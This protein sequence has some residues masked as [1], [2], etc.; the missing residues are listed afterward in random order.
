MQLKY[1]LLLEFLAIVI[2]EHFSNVK[3][4]RLNAEEISHQGSG[5]HKLKRGALSDLTLHVHAA[6]F[7]LTW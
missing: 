5:N 4:Y 2:N 6:L 1:I 7:S 3:L